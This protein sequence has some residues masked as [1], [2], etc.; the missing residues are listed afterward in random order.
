MHTYQKKSIPVPDTDRKAHL[1]AQPQL[2]AETQAVQVDTFGV[3]KDL[4]N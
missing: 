2:Q 3:H 1:P 4:W